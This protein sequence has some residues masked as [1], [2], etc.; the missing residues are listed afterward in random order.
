LHNK[1]SVTGI[2][3]FSSTPSFAPNFFPDPHFWPVTIANV[4]AIATSLWR[5]PR[6][7][8]SR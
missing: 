6:R 5:P 8:S 2:L 4:V 7:K 1:S 3:S